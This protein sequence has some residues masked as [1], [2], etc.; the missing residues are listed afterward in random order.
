MEAGLPSEGLLQ[1]L[2]LTK[3]ASVRAKRRNRD[4]L[5]LSQA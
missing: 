5:V 4:F 1:V 3:E 2:A